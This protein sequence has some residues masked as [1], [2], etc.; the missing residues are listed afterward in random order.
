MAFLSASR[1]APQRRAALV[2]LA[3][4]NVAMGA[5][6]YADPPLELA[7]KAT[8]LYKLAPFVSWPGAAYV[9]PN[10]PLTICVQ[11]VDPFGA[12]LDQAVGGQV[13]DGHPLAV[14]RLARLDA[15]SGCQSAYLAGGPAQSPAQALAAVDGAP[16]LTVTD[17]SRGGTARG[18]V[19]LLID[20]GRVRFSI[21][22]AQAE[23]NGVA[24]SSK[25]LVLAVAV[26]R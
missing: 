5:P 4:L 24:I 18:I 7:V 13:V 14:R 12:V 8:Y 9:A 15:G 19:H 20:G 22:A 26:K 10:G 25:L 16:V 2:A 21:D 23:R 3:V 11:G 6:A 17:D 1:Q